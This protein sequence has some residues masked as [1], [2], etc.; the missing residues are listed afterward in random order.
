M[1]IKQDVE[2]YY[3]T[4]LIIIHYSFI[5]HK[6]HSWL[7][8]DTL[9]SYFGAVA[10]AIFI[11][12]W[13]DAFISRLSQ[14]LYLQPVTFCKRAKSISLLRLKG[15]IHQNWNMYYVVYSPRKDNKQSKIFI[16]WILDN[17]IDDHI[18]SNSIHHLM[19]KSLS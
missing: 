10:H 6:Y 7:C 4:R 5:N 17:V 3:S 13:R 12:K 1:I 16:I 9:S 19:N 18:L 2:I 15:A 8:N 14:L 11:L